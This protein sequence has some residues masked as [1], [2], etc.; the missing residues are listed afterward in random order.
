MTGAGKFRIVLITTPPDGTGER[1]ARLLVEKKL[2]ACVNRI[3]RIRSVYRWEGRIESEEEELLLVKTREDLLGE[4]EAL[5]SEE[6]PYDVPELLSL[7]PAEGAD[8]Y[9]RWLSIETGGEDR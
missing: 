1:L 6:H 3:P 2:A 8:D 9:L 4:V 7:Q 5:L